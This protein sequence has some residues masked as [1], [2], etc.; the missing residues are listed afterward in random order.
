MTHQLVPNRQTTHGTLSADI[1]P[2]LHVASGDSV[3]LQTLDAWWGLEP[4]TSPYGPRRVLEHPD[5]TRGH[6]LTGPISIEGLL[7]GEVLEIRID[8]LVPASHG[9]TECG[10]VPWPHYARL[11][12]HIGGP[13]MLLWDIDSERATTKLS[14]GSFSVATQPFLGWMGLMPAERG[15]HSTTPP[16]P[17]GGNLDCNL[18]VAGSTLFLPVEVVGGLLSVGD[19]HAAQGD[20]ELSNNGIECAMDEIQLTLIRRSDMRLRLPLVKTDTHWA[21]IGLGDTIDAAAYT[22]SNALL[23]LIIQTQK[24]SRVEALGVASIAANLKIT[25][26]VNG[27]VGVHATWPFRS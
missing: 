4:F 25:Q 2:V 14:S 8:H 5:Q 1:A 15:V 26:L 23:D 3:R 13:H 19:G 17:T 6:C 7:P 27:V 24:C 18:L 22:A 11:G 16:R 12:A 9:F 20:A 21:C 10:G